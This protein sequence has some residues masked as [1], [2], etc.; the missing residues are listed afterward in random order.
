MNAARRLL[1]G[2]LLSAL[3]WS[4]LVHARDIPGIE[5]INR[6]MAI[7]EDVFL[8]A[9][10]RDH[11]DEPLRIASVKAHYLPPGSIMIDV[12]VI[13]NWV[14]VN[15]SHGTM[16]ISADLDSM[17]E[18]PKLVQDILSDL[19]ISL[20]PYEAEQ[21]DELRS[22]RQEQA[23]LRSEQRDIRGKLRLARRKQASTPSPAIEAEIDSMQRD[24]TASE[25]QYAAVN[26][27]IDAQYT[28]LRADREKLTEQIREEVQEV[29]LDTNLATT[30]CTYAGTLKALAPGGYLNIAIRGPERISYLAFE[31]D[32]ILGCLGGGSDVATL[33][34][35]AYR[36]DRPL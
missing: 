2:L 9:L 6:Q 16:Q 18:I 17:A 30:A 34:A 11:S 1:S 20:P 26:K 36:Y 19:S 27:D 31:A 15:R 14:T 35:Q 5:G 3:L 25:A 21:L 28:R 12:D 22:L 13:A 33:L 7:V 8:S 10:R 23:E 32:E 29:D 24:L 4:P